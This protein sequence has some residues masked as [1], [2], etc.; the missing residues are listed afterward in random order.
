MGLTE[1]RAHARLHH[2]VF[3]RHEANGLG[4]T[5]SQLRRRSES[6]ELERIER[7]VFAIAGVPTDWYQRARIATLTT[8]GVL[9]H[10]SALV[11]HE[12]DGF[13]AGPIH[14]T[15]PKARAVQRRDVVVHRSTQFDQIRVQ[16]IRSIPVTH[17]ERALLDYAGH[18]GRRRLDWAVDAALRQNTCDLGSLFETWVGHSIQGRNGSGPMRQLLDE[19]DARDPVPDSR[20]NR[21]V[22]RLIEDS[23]LPRPVYEHEISG[24]DGRFLAR[25]DLAFPLHRVAI[26]LDSVRWH[27]NRASFEAD[28]RR[29]NRLTIAGWTLLTFTW[30]DYVDQPARLIS[31]VESALRNAA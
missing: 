13:N 21:M 16:T 24:A 1:L 19:R 20:W 28:P 23:N 10:R 12:L 11:V 26:E 2:G 18:V 14:V 29:K 27:L 3:S 8:G 22:G 31:T 9:S 25:V 4:V 7:G 30:S 17:V 5:D 15:I 6:G